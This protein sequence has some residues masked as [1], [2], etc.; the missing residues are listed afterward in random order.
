MERQDGADGA[1]GL[2]TEGLDLLLLVDA[3]E[4]HLGCLDLAPLGCSKESNAHDFLTASGQ[5]L[6]KPSGDNRTQ[7]KPEGFVFLLKNKA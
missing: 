5:I 6:M 1:S 3:G 7:G 4:L 2:S